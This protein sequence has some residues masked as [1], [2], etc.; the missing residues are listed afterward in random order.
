MAAVRLSCGT[1]STARVASIVGFVRKLWIPG[2]EGRL[3]AA[4][5]VAVPARATAVITH[6]HPLHGG[7]LHNPVVFHADRELNRAGLTTL[8]FNFRGVGT[9]DG[10]HDGGRGEVDDLG[11]AVTWLRGVN[12]GVPLLLIGY[13]F[14]SICSIR[15]MTRDP[16]VSGLVAIGLPVNRYPMDELGQLER[17]VAVVQADTDEFGSV[18]EVRRVMAAAQPGGSVL[19]VDDTTH[20][21][22]GRAQAAAGRVVEAAELLLARRANPES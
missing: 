16:G 15:Y 11:H 3:E 4:F 5:R 2:P 21:F 8:R 1:C 19:V 14:G 9:S 12:P 22:P 10:K 18:Q 7:T 17:P 20:L 13:S 6:P